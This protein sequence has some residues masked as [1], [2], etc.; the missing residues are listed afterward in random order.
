MTT[1]PRTDHRVVAARS[2]RAG[3]A[4]RAAAEEAVAVDVS[5]SGGSARAA[6]GRRTESRALIPDPQ[7]SSDDGHL[8]AAARCVPVKV[9]LSEA[10]L[11]W[12][13]LSAEVGSETENTRL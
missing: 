8:A 3:P 11:F 12:N 10:L 13:E 1:S 5:R 7:G 6:P 9:R 2:V 4:R